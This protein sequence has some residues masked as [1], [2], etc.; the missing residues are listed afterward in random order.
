VKVRTDL[1]GPLTARERETALLV[2]EG[3]TDRQIAWRLFVS[4]RTVHAHLR[5]VYT[6]TGARNRVQ[7]AG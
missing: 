3:L 7:L 2:A 1:G 5:A 6:K 4:E